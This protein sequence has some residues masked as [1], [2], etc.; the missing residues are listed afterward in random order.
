MINTTNKE[1]LHEYLLIKA[2]EMTNYI[3]IIIII[4]GHSFCSLAFPNYGHSLSLLN[5]MTY[6][7]HSTIPLLQVSRYL[8]LFIFAFIYVYL[9]IWDAFKFSWQ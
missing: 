4:F 3:I 2:K 6:L 8:L 5:H 9:D 7:I 1:L